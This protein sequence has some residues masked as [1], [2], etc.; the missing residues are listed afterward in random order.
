MNHPSHQP[1][2]SNSEPLPELSIETLRSPETHEAQLRTSGFVDKMRRSFGKLA[3]LTAL[4]TGVLSAEPSDV[5]AKPAKHHV[6][7]SKH[8]KH[9]KQAKHGNHIKHPKH[10]KQAHKATPTPKHKYPA[11]FYSTPHAV[12]KSPE[13][14]ELPVVQHAQKNTNTAHVQ[15][16]LNTS[17][18][19]SKAKIAELVKKYNVASVSY[20]LRII[21]NGKRIK[22]SPNKDKGIATV[23]NAVEA[24]YSSRIKIPK[25][26]GYIDDE[27]EI[28]QVTAIHYYLS[29]V[30]TRGKKI[31]L[32]LDVDFII[33]VMS[34]EGRV[35]NIYESEDPWSNPI[36]GFGGLGLDWFSKDFPHIA[37]MGLI[38]H[39]FTEF[40]TPIK[41]TNEKCK[42]VTSA[43]FINKGAA[44]H[45]VVAEIAYRQ[46][47]ALIRLRKMGIDLSTLPTQQ[48]K[49]VTRFLTYLFYNAGPGSASEII[50]P[51][52]TAEELHAYFARPQTD[53]GSINLTGS[54]A[55]CYVVM[56]GAE[57]L[58]RAGATDPKAATNPKLWWTKE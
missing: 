54:P 7:H 51:Y 9:E 27:R 31:G 40:Y 39:K 57:W 47:L 18:N 48:R 37:E 5:D 28:Q 6:P 21:E 32:D 45:A 1:E 46:K 36:D 12:P 17:L 15:H 29:K 23:R 49:D 26:F 33:G 50:K 13:N 10:V 2:S 55:N 16:G 19:V 8:A 41:C 38:D 4:G 56:A 34:N 24:K 11:K 53:P 42:P 58:K 22:N 14:T 43:D 35:L 30:M 25:W 20:A 52:K 44:I 3:M